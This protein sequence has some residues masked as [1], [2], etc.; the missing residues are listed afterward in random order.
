MGKQQVF[1]FNSFT[2]KFLQFEPLR[3]KLTALDDLQYVYCQV[4]NNYTVHD[5]FNDQGLSST[6]ILNVTCKY[7]NAN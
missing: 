4:L 2:T 6:K 1:K 7:Y 5:N 3:I